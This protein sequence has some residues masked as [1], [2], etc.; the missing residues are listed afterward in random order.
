M[1]RKSS[2]K[3]EQK[4]QAMARKVSRAEKRERMPSQHVQTE[5][6]RLE[7]RQTK[8]VQEVRS[9]KHAASKSLTNLNETDES[10]EEEVYA[11]P[12]KPQ[13]DEPRRYAS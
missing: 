3:R 8:L 2:V 7:I 4:D 11:L 5:P 12:A 10:S 13:P 9:T 6:T 1:L